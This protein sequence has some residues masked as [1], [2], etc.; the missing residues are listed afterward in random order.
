MGV[1]GLDYTFEKA[2]ANLSI[3]CKLELILSK[4]LG[5]EPAA[6]GLL[7]RFVMK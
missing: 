4:E 2:P 3:D 1:V 6:V 7:D 5:F